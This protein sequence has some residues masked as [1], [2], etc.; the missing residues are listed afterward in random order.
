MMTLQTTH[1]TRMHVPIGTNPD[2]HRLLLSIVPCHPIP[3]SHT[4]LAHFLGGEVGGR[5][6]CF[7]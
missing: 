7:S 1:H 2:T 6:W 4:S 3:L 5:A